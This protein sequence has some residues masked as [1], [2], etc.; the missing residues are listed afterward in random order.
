MSR[1]NRTRRGMALALA[2]GMLTLSA[3]GNTSVS[4]G[5]VHILKTGS[6]NGGEERET[7][8][9][10]TTA[11]LGVYEKTAN[12]DGSLYYPVTTAVTYSGETAMLVEWLV[13]DNAEVK[14]GDP[15]ATIQ[16]DYDTVQLKEMELNLERMKTDYDWQLISMKDSLEALKSNWVAAEKG[17]TAKK[18]AELEYQ[19]AEKNLELYRMSATGSM[20]ALSA[21]IAAFKERIQ[22]TTIVAKTDGIVRGRAYIKN[23]EI[24]PQNQTLMEIYDPSVVWMRVSDNTGE[25]RYN[26]EVTIETGNNR[27]RT[28]LYGKVVSADNI[29][30]DSLRKGYAYVELLDLPERVNWQNTQI[31][32]KT[33]EIDQVLM[34]DRKA[35]ESADGSYFVYL[36]ED[37]VLHKRQIMRGGQ[38]VAGCWVLQGLEEGQKVVISE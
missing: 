35:V 33:I 14:K 21:Q 13:E 22:V 37:G 15:L 6:E 34:V 10:T 18:R 29:L 28:T 12:F 9:E 20:D 5:E 23:G 30:P 1:I 38:V 27:K 11:Q 16:I 32:A 8:Y 17:S 3:C 36:V 7:V 31:K 4:N 2:L 25:L 24:L 19:K 26:M